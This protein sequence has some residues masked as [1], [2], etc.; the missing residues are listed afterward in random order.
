MIFHKRWLKFNVKLQ[1]ENKL[2]HELFKHLRTFERD[3]E[4]YEQSLHEHKVDHFPILKS[5]F[6]GSNEILDSHTRK[7]PVLGEKFSSR[8]TDFRSLKSNMAIFALPC[9]CEISF[10]P[11]KLQLKLNALQEDDVLLQ[12]FRKMN[13]IDFYKSLPVAE[14]C[15]FAKKFVCM[16]GSTYTC[17]QLFSKVKHV[18]SKP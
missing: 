10:A 6:D 13:P 15:K 14:Y 2:V 12:N 1:G 7:V 18:K 16:F 4:V 5:I 11:V 17:E 8:F 9:T 3:L